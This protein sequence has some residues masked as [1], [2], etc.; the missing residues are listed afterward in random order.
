MPRLIE[1]LKLKILDSLVSA[2]LLTENQIRLII[3]DIEQAERR[4]H[5]DN[6]KESDWDKLMKEKP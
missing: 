5:L 1:C 3:S 4:K 6:L 2:H